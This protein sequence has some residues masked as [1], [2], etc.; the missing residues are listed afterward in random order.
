M[1]EHLV[2]GE[3][4]VEAMSKGGCFCTLFPSQTTD[5]ITEELAL[6]TSDSI[7][8][9][10]VP[11]FIEANIVKLRVKD[12]EAKKTTESFAMPS[13]VIP[14]PQN[15]PGMTPGSLQGVSRVPQPSSVQRFGALQNETRPPVNKGKERSRDPSITGFMQALTVKEKVKEVAAVDPSMLF[16]NM[17]TELM[18]L[19]FTS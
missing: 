4:C 17:N 3:I 16:C 12:G 11:V 6:E 1:W 18:I 7:A 10:E 15:P 5:R 19:T 14:L 13:A 9:G 8:F 2:A